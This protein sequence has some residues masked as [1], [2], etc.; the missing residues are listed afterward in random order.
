MYHPIQLAILKEGR[1]G[2]NTCGLVIKEELEEEVKCTEL[3][4][5]KEIESIALGGF[6]FFRHEEQRR[7]EGGWEKNKIA[8]ERNLGVSKQDPL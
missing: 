3:V 2:G 6:T 4:I 7:R 5:G 8:D 1:K